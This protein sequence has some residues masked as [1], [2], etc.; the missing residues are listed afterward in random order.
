[1]HSANNFTV[2]CGVRTAG[3]EAL[4]RSGDSASQELP[5]LAPPFSSAK[6]N[7]RVAGSKRCNAGTVTR[8]VRNVEKNVTAVHR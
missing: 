5:G 1:M 2:E 7:V 8:T 4:F 6:P 3:T